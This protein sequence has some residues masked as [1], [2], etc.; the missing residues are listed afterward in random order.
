MK[1]PEVRQENGRPDRP[2]QGGGAGGRLPALTRSGRLWLTLSMVLLIVGSGAGNVLLA[3]CGL[4]ALS[5][6]L[7]L[8]LAYLPAAVLLWRRYLELTFVLPQA[9]PSGAS[10]AL[11]QAHDGLIAGRPFPLLVTLRNLGVLPVG[12]AEL[13]IYASRS[14]R[15]IAPPPVLTLGGRC[16]IELPLSLRAAQ[17]GQW[18]LHGAALTLSDPLGLFAVEAY[19]PSPLPIKVLPRTGPRATPPPMR[20][21]VGAPDERLGV[22]TL[23]H[24]GLGGELRE[25]RDYSPG[26]PFKLI[27]WKASARAPLGRLLV[28]DLDRETLLTHYLLLDIGASMREGPPGHTK[29]DHALELCQHYARAVLEGGDSVGLIT[30]DGY[31]YSHLPPRGGAAQ[32]LRLTERL[33]DVMNVVEERFCG[34]PDADVCVAVARYLR[35]QEGLEARLSRTPGMDDPG[36]WVHLSVGPSGELYDMRK[37]AAAARRILNLS[38]AE[39]PR[40]SPGLVSNQDQLVLRLFCQRRGIEVPYLRGG[41]FQGRGVARAGGLARALREVA[42][43]R[44]S[45]RVVVLSDLDGLAPGLLDTDVAAALCRRRGHRLTLLFPRT[46]RYLPADLLGDP[47]AA[48]AAEIFGW[49]IDRREDLMQAALSQRG[50]SVIPVGPQDSLAQLMNRMSSN[51]F[52]VA[53]TA[54]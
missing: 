27:A 31:I 47:G 5:A 20:I 40:P 36:I 32:R 15:A 53:K 50:F 34:V 22:H 24:R 6:L 45:R 33:L 19:F 4:C 42:T 30:Y 54:P 2:A 37:L 25:L 7:T 3:A 11:A 28:R 38:P 12:R 49:E 1:R 26:D 10:L 51:K 21:S 29:L 46:R 35:Q 8:Y 48:R 52:Q 44:G 13:H 43:A 23:R 16:E 39:E 41:S 17:A 18:A 9:A 14:I